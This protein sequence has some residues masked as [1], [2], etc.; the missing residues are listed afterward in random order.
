[1]G[2]GRRLSRLEGGRGSGR[3]TCGIFSILVNGEFV[4]ASRHGVPLSEEEWR[5]YDAANTGGVCQLC[6]LERPPKIKIGGPDHAPRG[7]RRRAP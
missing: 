3:C 7:P 5:A 1:M 4:R 2:I 6:G